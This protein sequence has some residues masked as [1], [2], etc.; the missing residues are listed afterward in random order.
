M[1]RPQRPGAAGAAICATAIGLGR[2]MDPICTPTSGNWVDQ[3]YLPDG[4]QQELA[5][6]HPGEL[7]WEQYR[8]EYA[9]RTEGGVLLVG[10]AAEA[11]DA[12]KRCAP[13]GLG[14]KAPASEP[15]SE[16]APR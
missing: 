5:F 1:G 13:D 12:D 11:A 4:L 15:G 2:G 10:H 8:N 3:R 16:D 7:G 6:Y 9:R 14:P